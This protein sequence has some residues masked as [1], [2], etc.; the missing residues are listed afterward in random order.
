MRRTLK[1][2]QTSQKKFSDF[3]GAKGQMEE[4]MQIHV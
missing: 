3:V 2:G 1:N 4:F